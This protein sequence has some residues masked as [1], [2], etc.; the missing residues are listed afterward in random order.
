MVPDGDGYYLV[1]G[2]K[3]G[4]KA[5]C[6]FLVA[7]YDNAGRLDSAFAKGGV[8]TLTVGNASYATGATV[9]PDGDLLVSGWSVGRKAEASVV[10]LHPNGALDR[11]F[12]RN[13]VVRIPTS[14]VVRT[15]QV[16]AEPDGSVWLAWSVISNSDTY[17]GNY[18]VGHLRP[19]GG[20][21]STFGNRG[22]RTFNIN[23]VDAISETAVDAVGR[24]FVTGWSSP[25]L[26][27]SGAAAVVSVDDGK[28]TYQRTINPWGNRGTYVISSDVDPDGSLVVGMTPYSSPGWGAMRLKGDLRLDRSY[29]R[30]GVAKHDCRCFS[31]TGTFTP[32]GLVLI[33][34]NLARD[35]RTVLAHFTENGRWDA[36][37]AR[38]GPWQAIDGW[39]LWES[40]AV[41]GSGRLLIAGSGQNRTRD[42]LIA[43][44]RLS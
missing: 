28:R 11:S 1:G 38:F 16:E 20:R 17:R 41:D 27:Q 31:S 8:K 34:G 33:G 32:D 36:K 15:P 6:A 7:R 43:R 30:D 37:A 40:A 42:A 5:D 10:A 35:N 4:Q 26:K 22:V 39:E 2:T 13:G 29:G 9:A 23:D 18:Q 3:Q 44:L 12:G 19:N 25:S 24:L 21:D 14:G